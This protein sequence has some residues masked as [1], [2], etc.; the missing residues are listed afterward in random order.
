[1]RVQLESDGTLSFEEGAERLVH[2]ANVL[3]VR[4]YTHLNDDFILEARPGDKA[5]DVLE[6]SRAVLD[7][8]RKRGRNN[9]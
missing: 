8:M 9:A 4:A 6:R 5:E 7:F 1:M 2:V 3:G